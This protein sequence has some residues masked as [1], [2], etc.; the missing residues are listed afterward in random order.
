MKLCIEIAVHMEAPSEAAAREFLDVR[1][2]A[3]RLEA[4]EVLGVREI[5][6][7]HGVEVKA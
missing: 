3:A 5:D 4:T 1:L 7:S 6:E 2:R